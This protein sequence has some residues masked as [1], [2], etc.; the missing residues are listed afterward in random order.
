LSAKTNDNG[1]SSP[2][3]T[4]WDD[5]LVTGMKDVEFQH[6]RLLEIANQLGALHASGA[7][8]D[9]ITVILN[10][11]KLEV[12]S[13]VEQRIQIE[14]ELRDSKARFRTMAD[15]T[16][17]WEYW[18]GQDG[19]IIYTSPSCKRITGHVAEEFVADPDLMYRII[20]PEDKHVME[21]HQKNVSLH[22][23]E[24]EELS[25]RILRNDG[26]IRW[27]IHSCKVLYD[28]D[29]IFIGRRGSN[30]DITERHT[31][32]DSMLLVATVF[33]SVNEAVLVT[34]A[35]NRIIVVNTSFTGI[36]GY[37]PEDAIGQE[38]GMLADEVSVADLV[39]AQWEKLTATG[40]WQGEMINRRKNGERY[41]AWVSIDSVRDDSGDIC[42]FILVFSDIS[43][44]K[45][46]EKRLQYL[47]H[48]DQLTGLPNWTLFSDRIQQAILSAQRSNRYA[49][50]MF[51]DIDHFKQAKDKLGHDLGDLLLKEVANRIRRCLRP[52]DTAARIG[53]DEF[54]VLLPEIAMAQDA[55][56]VA[57][58]VL[59]V[60]AEPF[61]LAHHIVRISVSVG[62]A[63]YP[64]HGEDV[65]QIMKSADLAM[66]QAKQAGGA[67]AITFA[68]A[69]GVL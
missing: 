2:P 53:S 26:E 4:V 35:D 21:S 20:H 48:Y 61:I 3:T 10:E 44:R 63:L 40:R 59:K 62:I 11:L 31:Q 41:T 69:D 33:E 23:D 5:T 34:D 8:S 49:A 22:E 7:T 12:Q 1:S 60:M 32:Y 29:G 13:G 52:S 56:I 51:V 17:S 65:G 37:A 30:R 64:E 57:D 27:I 15:H 58:K 36:T 66:Y 54:V 6:Q 16:H 19:N 14:Q 38:P 55:E 47:T 68:T 9:Q 50:L 28:Q 67:I 39:K 46:N 18:Q 42:N 43:E 45:E 24:D 25:F